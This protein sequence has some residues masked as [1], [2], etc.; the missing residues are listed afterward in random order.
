MVEAKNKKTKTLGQAID[1]ISQILKSIDENSQSIAINAVIEQLNL[2]ME[3]KDENKPEADTPPLHKKIKDFILYKNPKDGYQRLA[4][5]AYYLEKNKSI[6][7]FKAQDLT[8]ANTD[9]KQSKFSN[10]SLYLSDATR[11]YGYFSPSSKGKKVL[12]TTGEAVVEALPDQEKVREVSKKYKVR[13]K[14]RKVNK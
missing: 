5:L 1:E 6:E 9:A 13:T 11:K 8:K 12:T 4:C 7:E 10:I 14:K 2:K 3:R